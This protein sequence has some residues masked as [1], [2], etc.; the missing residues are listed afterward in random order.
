MSISQLLTRYISICGSSN[1]AII[2]RTK[3]DRSS[4]YK[5][6]NGKRMP[7]QEQA[8]RIIR[9]MMLPYREE[10]QLRDML[11][12][13][14]VGEREWEDRKQVQHILQ[15]LSE[16]ELPVVTSMLG[17]LEL[18]SDS[19]PTATGV[20]Q[21]NQMLLRFIHEA[22]SSEEAVLD[23]FVDARNDSFFN[24]LKALCSL[25][26][27]RNIQLRQLLQLPSGEG[28]PGE[29]NPA[30]KY[31]E[32]ITYFFSMTHIDLQSHYYYERMTRP[33]GIGVLFPYYLISAQGVLLLNEDFT[34]AYLLRDPK[35]CALYREVFEDAF[36]KTKP[37]IHYLNYMEHAKALENH[38]EGISFYPV[39]SVSLVATKER[40]SK[41]VRNPQ[42]AEMFIQHCQILREKCPVLMYSTV[43]GMRRFADTGIIDELPPG[44]ISAIPVAERIGILQDYRTFL[45]NR[46]FFV[47]EIQMPTSLR[48]AITVYEGDVMYLYRPV[49]EI[50]GISR[51]IAVRERNVQDAF[52]TYFNSLA[53]GAGLLD[54]ETAQQEVDRLIA[55]LREKEKQG[56]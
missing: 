42:L 19:E 11:M 48:W 29:E 5:I 15:M 43:E 55:E 49:A 24:N 46:L 6:L 44:L 12:R 27:G 22:L 31:F 10:N 21:T 51:V 47:N 8:E 3:I 28:L 14:V 32:E 37:V 30:L 23:F 52:S 7:T 34:S 35:F 20:S 45:G 13:L 50:N 18:Q 9:A 36:A 54:T 56:L 39:F 26:T 1:N 2:R 41:Y 17:E 53:E 33:G 25:Q 38:T 4:F 40:I 16:P